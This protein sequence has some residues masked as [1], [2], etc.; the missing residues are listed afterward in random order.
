[1]YQQEKAKQFAY[2]TK[3]LFGSYYRFLH[4]IIYQVIWQS[5]SYDIQ[6][7]AKKT[8]NTYIPEI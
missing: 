2:S 8:L 7:V 5:E 1:M 3:S 6:Y 4:A